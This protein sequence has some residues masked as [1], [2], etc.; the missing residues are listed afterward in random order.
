MGQRNHLKVHA[1]GIVIFY[2][3]LVRDDIIRDFSYYYGTYTCP[4]CGKKS[5]VIDLMKNYF[6]F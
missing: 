4:K 6:G 5:V 3:C 1:F 2:I